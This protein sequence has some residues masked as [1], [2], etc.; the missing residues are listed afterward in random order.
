MV[1][2]VPWNENYRIGVYRI[3]LEHE[4][5]FRLANL[6][7]D[8]KGADKD[9]LTTIFRGL[10]KYTKY[11]FSGEE[12]LMRDLRYPGLT[13]QKILHK[14]IIRQMEAILQRA[15]DLTQLQSQLQTFMHGWIVKHVLEVDLRLA[16]HIKTNGLEVPKSPTA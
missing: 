13:E 11:H 5:L 3:D 4:E 12:V 9:T 2:N 7:L 1:W 14:A 10:Y 15:N 8:L 16:E 6:V